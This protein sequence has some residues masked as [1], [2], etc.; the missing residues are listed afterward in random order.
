MTLDEFSEELKEV[1]AGQYAQISHDIYAELF[2]PGE[3]DQVARDRCAKFAQAR[4]FRIENKPDHKA[5][6]FVKNA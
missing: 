1:K 2:P 4:G 3:P 6:W 5:I